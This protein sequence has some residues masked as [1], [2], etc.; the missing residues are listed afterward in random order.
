MF[1]NDL[2]KLLLMKFLGLTNQECN[3]L[4]CKNAA[5]VLSVLVDG[6]TAFSW[7]ALI[8]DLQSRALTLFKCSTMITEMQPKRSTSQL[9]YMHGHCH[10]VE[11]NREMYSVPSVVSIALY[12][13]QIKKKVSTS[14]IHMAAQTLVC[15]CVH[16][17]MCMCVCMCVCVR[18]C[19]CVY[20]QFVCAQ[21]VCACV[22]ACVYLCVC[23]CMCVCVCGVHMC[24]CVHVCVQCVLHS[25]C[26]H[27]CAVCVAQCVC[28]VCVYV[29][30]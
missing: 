12:M 11:R 13:S 4:C 24:V 30:V 15:M 10:S 25:V 1:E 20:A 16:V 18:V 21:F 19:G 9:Q 8:N 27:V 3:E 14:T 26:V 22:C 17:C 7:D 23:V 2:R 28:T 29:C 6:L 5:S